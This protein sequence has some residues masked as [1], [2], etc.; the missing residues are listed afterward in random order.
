MSEPHTDDLQSLLEGIQL[1]YTDLALHPEMDFGWSNGKESAR[2]L[3]YDARWL[4]N[5]PD[6]VWQSAAPVGNPFDLGPIMPGQTVVDLGCGAGIDLCI[7]ASLIGDSGRA[8]GID[9]TPA[10][11]EKAKENARL[12]GLWDVEVYVGDIADVPLGDVCAAAPGR[13]RLF[14][15]QRSRCHQLNGE[16]LRNDRC[17]F[18]LSLLPVACPFKP[19]TSVPIRGGQT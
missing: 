4:D 15:F 9:I 16:A 12:L 8:I 3:G 10:M 2:Q 13:S 1:L 7:A 18:E 5:F 11:V 6:S 19:E 14:Q 17:Y